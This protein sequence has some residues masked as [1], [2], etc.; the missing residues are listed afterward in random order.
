MTEAAFWTKAQS[1]VLFQ[2]YLA[3]LEMDRLKSKVCKYSQKF[4]VV[5]ILRYI[6]F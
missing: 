5:M 6:S 2:Y 4:I 3:F 1:L